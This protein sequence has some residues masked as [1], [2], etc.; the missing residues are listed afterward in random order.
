MPN[1]TVS[2]FDHRGGI[3]KITKERP[4]NIGLLTGML[5][6]LSTAGI[7]L[8]ASSSI[9]IVAGGGSS[10]SADPA[11]IKY[12]NIV[13]SGTVIT[14]PTCTAGYDA[15]IFVAPVRFIGGTSTTLVDI[16]GVSTY[17]VSNGAT[18]TVTGQI[19]DSSATTYTAAET[20]QLLVF[21]RCCAAGTNCE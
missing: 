18:W 4:W 16:S 15:R 19:K 17:A 6:L 7:A 21:T 9:M 8:S 14:K 2:W 1:D 12:T 20:L 13:P 11:A 3:M 10:S 5:F